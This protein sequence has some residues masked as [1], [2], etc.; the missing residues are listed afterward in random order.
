MKKQIDSDFP[1]YVRVV[2]TKFPQPWTVNTAVMRRPRMRFE[3]NSEV[4]TAPR[5]RS[6]PTPMLMINLQKT[7]TPM[8]FTAGPDPASAWTS[9]AVMM[10]ISSIPSD[11]GKV[12]TLHG[13]EN[14]PNHTHALSPN[15]V[16][17]PSE[18]QLLQQVFNRCR[19]LDSKIFV[20]R[21]LRKPARGSC[22]LVVHQSD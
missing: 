14:E 6:P 10:I 1:S 8:I 20:G 5:G 21:Q 7:M 19:Y 17:Q 4:I 16:C 11:C 18:Q 22:Q 3:A 2:R 12:R 9:V 13:A 15:Y